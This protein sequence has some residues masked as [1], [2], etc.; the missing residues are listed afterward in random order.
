MIQFSNPINGA[1]INSSRMSKNITIRTN[2]M[3]SIRAPYHGTVV[4]MKG[5]C[6]TLQHNVNGDEVY[7]KICKVNR[8][9]VSYNNS[10]RKNEIIGYG[11]NEDVEYSILDRGGSSVNTQPYFKGIDDIKDKKD[12]KNKKEVKDKKDAKDIENKKKKKIEPS[13]DTKNPAM[14]NIFTDVL[15][16]P[17]GL[18]HKLGTKGLNKLT[19]KKEDDQVNEE[20]NRIKQLLK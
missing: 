1:R 9:Q 2:P 13:V 10:I 11:G 8:P 16:S 19:G 18:A 20:I 17:L 14:A 3:D 6:I 5:D 7:S 4:D 15:L 12:I